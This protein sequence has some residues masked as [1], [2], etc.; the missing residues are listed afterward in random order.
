MNKI[1]VLA[2][3]SEKI[4]VGKFTLESLT[5]GMYSEPL[6]VFREY[7]QN[8]CD[9]IDLAVKKGILKDRKEGNINIQI[10]GKEKFFSIKDNG[11]GVSQDKAW[12]ILGD[13]GKSEKRVEEQRGFRGIGRLGGISYCDELVFMTSFKNENIKTIIKWDCK[14]LRE[15]LKPGKFEDYD[16]I[17][18]MS[19]IS[20]LS[21]EREKKKSHYFIVEL[22][23]I[24]EQHLDLLNIE[25][26][27]SYL[28]EVAPVP[29]NQK[30]FNYINEIKNEFRK[31][32]FEIPEYEIFL[33]EN[34]NRLTKH[35][36]TRV[37]SSKGSGKTQ[38][39][40]KQDI[41]KS[42]IV[43]PP[44][45]RDKNS[46]I[47]WIGRRREF[48]ETIAIKDK[49]VSGIRLRKG[50]IQIG[51]NEILKHFF[52]EERFNHYFIGEIHILSNN[53]I[54][55]ARRDDFE[56]AGDYI[57]ILS[58]LERI[59]I[60]L[61]EDI[62]KFNREKSKVKEF[63]KAI[64]TK[65]EIVK[66]AKKGFSSKI[67]QEIVFQDID[68]SKKIFKKISNDAKINEKLKRKAIVKLEE[69]KDLENKVINNKKDNYLISNI[70]NSYSRKEKKII[71][72]VFEIIDRLEL[73]GIITNEQSK[74]IIDKIIS[75]FQYSKMSGEK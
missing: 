51:G 7:I 32:N 36:K 72:K 10:N 6:T 70:P 58:E 27:Q 13:I 24:G 57:N 20:S 54:P 61:S 12:K 39:V 75:E 1:N 35:Y 15:L 56:K 74:K 45:K 41:V 44:T 34:P 73:E 26:V 25:I 14:K 40:Q 4:T 11:I 30:H 29:F 68:K 8:S 67:E 52:K 71:L 16:I 23:G 31:F 21:K 43:L 28:K 64:E 33:N 42:E 48:D 60:S 38:K 9:S 18:V 62:R 17:K 2:D 59:A 65:K 49:I 46:F 37:I 55:N 66:K 5:T 47:G 50:N 3:N 63:D 69:L 22:R 19:S 53:V